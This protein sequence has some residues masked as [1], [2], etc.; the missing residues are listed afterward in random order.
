MVR[1]TFPQ[2]LYP[3]P[4]SPNNPAGIVPKPPPSINHQTRGRC[5][6]FRAV[7][8]TPNAGKQLTIWKI[9]SPGICIGRRTKTPPRMVLLVQTLVHLLSPSR[10]PDSS[11]QRVS[12]H[13]S[14]NGHK[15]VLLLDAL[16]KAKPAGTIL[17]N[18][19]KTA[20][21]HMACGVLFY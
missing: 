8:N 21:C 10:I 17:K 13:S 3:S 2:A 15:Y 11:G 5:A 7:S 14:L 19:P 18:G 4:F 16:A 12:H 9:H 1:I 6:H 20:E